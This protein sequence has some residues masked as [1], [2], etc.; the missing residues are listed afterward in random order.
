MLKILVLFYIFAGILCFI[1]KIHTIKDI[2]ATNNVKV[3]T[4]LGAT[5]LIILFWPIMP[6]I[7][8]DK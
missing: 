8:G 1:E 5:I 4:L 7:Y 2:C 6:F 3:T